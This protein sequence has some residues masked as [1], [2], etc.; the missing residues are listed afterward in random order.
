MGASY[1]QV[2]FKD[3]AATSARNPPNSSNRQQSVQYGRRGAS[4]QIAVGYRGVDHGAQLAPHRVGAR[5]QHLSHEDGDQFF[6]GVDPE[7]RRRSTSPG[8]LAGAA[9]NQR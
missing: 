3:T 4:L 5:G 9:E 2:P 8:K 6:R 1:R 7:R